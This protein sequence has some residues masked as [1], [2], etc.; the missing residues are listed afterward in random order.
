MARSAFSIKRWILF[1]LL[2]AALVSCNNIFETPD[3]S[4]GNPEP[5]PGGTV[6]G[7]G[8]LTASLFIPDYEQ[9]S[10]AER[11][12]APQTAKVRLSIKGDGPAFAEFKTLT[13]DPKD[14]VPV[15]NQGAPE[16]LPGGVWTGVFPSLKAGAYVPGNLKIELLDAA[17]AVLTEGFNDESV[18]VSADRAVSAVFYT[19]PV[20]LA[21]SGALRPGEM[22]FSKISMIGGLSYKLILNTS[23]PWP[24]LV[25]FNG[26]GTFHSYHQVNGSMDGIVDFSPA[27]AVSYYVGVYADSGNVSSYNLELKLVDDQLKDDDVI[28]ENFENSGSVL[29]SPWTSSGTVTVT[30]QT[31]DPWF[32]NDTRF[33]RMTA[34]ASVATLQRS[35]NLRV[36]S[37]MTFTFRTET[38]TSGPV[39]R[40]YVDNV[41]MGAWRGSN[42]I[43]RTE[44]FLL[45]AGQRSIRFELSSGATA[46]AVYV[47]NVNIV[48][49]ITT[50]VALSPKGDLN[51]YVDA[52]DN[53]KIVFRGQA[54]RYDGSVRKNVTDFVY[55]GS[56]VNSDT[57]VFT[58]PAAGDTSVSV[59]ID[60]KTASKIVT[61][62]P[63]DYMR[64]PFYYS[65]TGK[66]YY[67]YQGTTGTRTTSGGV[68]VTY[69]NE[70]TFSA[71]G[72][73]TVE[74]RVNNSAVYNYAYI[75]LTK[76]SDPTNLRT[77]YLVRD[78][79]KKRIWLRFGP[80]PYTIY[81]YGLSSITLSSELGAE[82]DYRGCSFNTSTSPVSFRVTNTRSDD[83]SADGSIPDK[84]F[85]YPSYLVQSD[86]YRIS[87]LAADLTY[88][89]ETV[90][91]KAKAFH[92]YIITNTVYDLDSYYDVNSRKKQDA[93]TVLG[94]RY[95]K[96][97][98]YEPEG[99][100]V[101]VCEGYSQLNAALLRS[102]GVEINFIGSDSLG[103]AWNHAFINGGWKLID[104][105]W[106]DPLPS[107]S[108]FSDF[109]PASVRYTN[110]LL[111]N[112]TGGSSAHTGGAQNN[113]RFLVNQSAPNH[114]GVPDGW[115]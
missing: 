110:F 45:L 42:T 30:N 65:G 44:S 40:L 52:P 92:D 84:R 28:L 74:G 12:V 77:Y 48:P 49:D 58:P 103:H 20:T 82:G 81:V 18:V 46:Y 90:D 17:G 70:Q 60:G 87:N 100:Y 11:A 72:F 31:T 94:T 10:R 91:A 23:G 109:G 67:G 36:D 27:A 78:E 89:L 83:F 8:S 68:T 114:R 24:D 29:P 101:A 35:I 79:F 32:G 57:G 71:D 99:H 106:D 50:S 115:Y 86:D 95:H 64:Q 25:I 62:H 1:V 21:D 56:G 3:N 107:A 5:N 2:I 66:T 98:Q 15:Q 88:G 104:L 54:L 41:E 113:G 53:E 37:A 6:D 63:A 102:L 19:V 26:N 75:Q 97:A 85:I 14:I 43:W 47:D 51:A 34:G 108:N 4:R 69:P 9:I 61:V 13:I 16:S 96:D 59:S 93:I 105:T 80:G 112:L 76:D 111:T 22:K 38:G 33:V 7:G 73:F 39:F 55:S